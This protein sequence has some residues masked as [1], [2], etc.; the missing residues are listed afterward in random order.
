[1]RNLTENEVQEVSGAGVGNDIAMGLAIGWTGAVAGFAVGSVV[2]G[3]G[4]AAGAVAGFVVGS[5][6]GIGFTLARSGDKNTAGS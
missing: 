2:P 4:N 6:A 1:M 3:V 5:V